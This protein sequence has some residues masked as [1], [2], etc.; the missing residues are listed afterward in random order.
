MKAVSCW[1]SAPSSRPPCADCAT[2]VFFA[3]FFA[4]RLAFSI[5]LA[6]NRFAQ[7]DSYFGEVR[8]RAASEFFEARIFTSPMMA[9]LAATL[10]SYALLSIGLSWISKRNRFF[11]AAALVF[12]ALCVWWL[13]FDHA[14]HAD[15]RYYFRTILLLGACGLAAVCGLQRLAAEGAPIARIAALRSSLDALSSAGCAR[16]ILGAV[17]LVV[18]VH[19]V[20]TA[21]F[22]R[23]FAAY[24]SAV[25]ALASGEAADPQLGAPFLVSSARIGAD[26]NRFAWFS[27]TPYLSALAADF[28]PKRL[29]VDPAGNYFW[30]SCATA[31]QA[32]QAA[33]AVPQQTRDM[34]RVYSCLH[35]N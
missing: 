27:T 18:A 9:L 16:F 28:A 33:G 34:I 11:V 13:F 19:V 20:E 6:V 25:H 8:L 3:R 26:L 35:R 31:A 7:P 17:C 10:A 15:N 12:G 4:L 5:W 22:A 23:G 2:R 32:A 21:K 30:L 24:R 29:V 14:I 1:A